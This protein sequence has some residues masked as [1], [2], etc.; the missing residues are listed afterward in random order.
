MYL[1]TNG[2]PLV[3]GLPN[4]FSLSQSVVVYFHMLVNYEVCFIILLL[5]MCLELD[6]LT[7]EGTSD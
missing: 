7:R 5:L 1:R 3:I 4:R 2:N 6:D